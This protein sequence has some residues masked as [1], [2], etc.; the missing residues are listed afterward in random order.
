MKIGILT[1]FHN[2]YNYG[3]HLQAFAILKILKQNGIKGEVIDFD[4]NAYYKPPRNNRNLFLIKRVALFLW[5]K[6]FCRFMK[7]KFI[8]R[9]R[10]FSEFDRLCVESV[11]K[12]VTVQ[13]IAILENFYDGFIVGSDQVWRF[14]NRD[15]QAN[16]AFLLN[17]SN[18]TKM[19]YSASLGLK[20]FPENAEVLLK[21]ELS[22]FDYI[23]V[24][25]EQSKDILKK[26][27][28]KE[29]AVTLDPTLLI[30]ESVWTQYKKPFFYKKKKY[31][32]CYFI[33]ESKWFRKTA[34]RYSKEWGMPS[35]SIP[36][37]S[38]GYNSSD[39]FFKSKKLYGVSPSHFLSLVSEAELVLTDSFHALVFSLL[40]KRKCQVFL[41]R[42]NSDGGMS[43]RI[44]DLLKKSNLMNLLVKDEFSKCLKKN[45]D[46]SYFEFEKYINDQRNKSLDFLLKIKKEPLGLNYS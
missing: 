33:S 41:R 27:T 9:K 44:V 22:K 17:F 40:F 36:Y 28:E 11:S 6:F 29:I 24:R 45:D 30:S 34:E 42:E 32:F 1:L 25:E 7:Q 5:R 46:I 18:K 26:F 12:T 10:A 2:N 13:N 3:A 21:K 8:E 23:S 20:K 39:F 35:Y 14:I 15:P 31:I 43:E 38:M 16:A 37:M 4:W 19:S